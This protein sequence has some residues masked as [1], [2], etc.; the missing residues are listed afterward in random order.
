MKAASLLPSL[1]SDYSLNVSYLQVFGQIP[2]PLGQKLLL[3]VAEELLLREFR[4][5]TQQRLGQLGVQAEK[6]AEASLED[7]KG[8][9]LADLD[10]VDHVVILNYLAGQDFDRVLLVLE[11]SGEQS[12]VVH[13]LSSRG[14]GGLS[15]RE[16]GVDGHGVAELIRHGLLDG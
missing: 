5:L 13:S 12:Y 9:A 16:E 14:D 7:P 4:Q 3:Q 11:P 8:L 2:L 6:Q 15:V 1:K 10:L